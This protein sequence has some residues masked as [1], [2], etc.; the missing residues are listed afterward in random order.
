MSF[1]AGRKPSRVP[2][3][4]RVALRCV[5]MVA[6]GALWWFVAGQAVIDAV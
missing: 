6:L 1:I 4:V 5:G 2:S 3:A